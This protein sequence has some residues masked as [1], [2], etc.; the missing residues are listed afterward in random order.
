MLETLRNLFRGPRES[1]S[2]HDLIVQSENKLSGWY[3]ETDNLGRLL[4]F[5]WACPGKVIRA[6]IPRPRGSAEAGELPVEQRIGCSFVSS[7][8]LPDVDQEGLQA[9][10]AKCGQCGN[11]S[12]LAKYLRDRRITT[13]ELPVR[14]R[15]NPATARRVFDTW[16][17]K[18]AADGRYA[19][20]YEKSDPGGLL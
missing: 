15:T 16:D 3:R 4:G 9:I 19:V 13:R 7:P 14:V 2:L 8:L 10:D 11:T 5:S 18:D 6:T 1:E 17:D 20:N 12:N